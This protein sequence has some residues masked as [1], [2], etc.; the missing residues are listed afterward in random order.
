M[1]RVITIL[2]FALLGTIV[3]QGQIKIGGNV[4][5]GGNQ[6]VVNGSTKVTVK[7]GDIGAILDPAAVRPLEDPK[8]KVFGGARMANVGGNTFV[9]IDGKSEPAVANT[10][11]ILINQVFGGND[12]AGNIGTAA[13]VGEEIPAELEAVKSS[14]PSPL[15]EGETEEYYNEVDNTF[16]SYVRVSTKVTDEHYTE[17]EI[18][19]A[20]SDPDNPAFGKSTTDVKPAPDAR[21]VYIGQLFA[22]GNGDYDYEQTPSPNP[23]K[24]IHTIYDKKDKNHQNP[25]AQLET[26]EGDV[27]FQF[28]ELD[29]TYLEIKGGSI[30]YGY[31]GGNNSTINETNIIHYDN[32]SAVVNH[33]KVDANGLLD[34]NGTDLLTTER[35]KEMGINTTFSQPSS[36]A[37][38]VGRFFG[39]NNLAEMHIR[40]M[41]NLLS[42]KI[43]NLYSGGNRGSMTNPDGLLLEIMGYSTLIV[44]NLYGGC[45]MADVMPTV[46]GVYVPCSN[47]P[48][49]KFPN[50][51]SA[52]T[53]VRGGHINNVYGGNDVTG[54]VYGGNAVGIYATVYGDV[55]GGGNGNYPYTDSEGMADDDTYGDFYYETS[56]TTSTEALS[57]FRPNAEQ[58]SLRLQGTDKDNPTVIQGSVFVGGN[59]ASLD[60]KK[61][62]PLIELKMGSYVT[63]ENVFLGNNGAGMINPIYLA[64]YAET[65]FSSLNLTDASVFSDYM[66]GVAMT[67]KPRLM[68]DNIVNGDPATYVEN[69]SFVGS[70]FCGGN[71]GSM[72]IPGK[73]SFTIDHNLVIYDK[74]VGGCNK[75]NV[76]AGTYNA[77]Y[78]GGVIGSK[79]E[80]NSYTDEGGNIKD[81]LE[82]NLA[83]MTLVP[84][85][86]NNPEVKD[87]LLWNKNKWGYVAVEAGT[88]L[89][90]G[91]IYYT[92]STGAEEFTATG[93]ETATGSNYYEQGFVPVRPGPGYDNPNNRLLGANA[94]GGCYE[95][96]HV[97][98]NVV[99]NINDDVVK[100]DEVFGTGTN[101]IGRPKSNIDFEGQRDD[102][103][104]ISMSVFGAGYGEDT[105]IWGNTAVNLNNGY[106]FQIYGGG[107]KGVVGK[108]RDVLDEHGEVI[109]E[110]Y[111]FDPA[112]SSTVNL[113]GAT[114]VYS[115]DDAPEDLAEAEYLYGG[116]NEGDVCGNTYVNLGNGRIYDA[117]GGASDADILGHTEVV[118]GRQPNGSGAYKSGFPWVQDIVY[119][120]NDFGGT[121]H[122]AYEDGFDYKPR[123]R[124]YEDY[125]KQLHG[126]DEGKH[127]YLLKGSSYV[128]YLQGRVDTIFGGSYG[129]YD[130]ADIA[131]YGVGNKMPRQESAFVNLRP[132]SNDRNSIVG[133]FGAGTGYP[134]ARD[135]DKA[136][137]H[138]YVLVD[139]PHENG[140]GFKNLEVFGSGSNNGLGMREDVFVPGFDLDKA[141][142][143]VDLL[144]GEIGNAYGGSYREGNTARTVVNVP[145][146]STIRVKNI[147][148]GAYGANILPPCDVIMTNVNYRNTSENAVVTGAIYGGNNSQRRSI[149]TNVFISS[150]VWSDKSKGYLATAYGAGKGFNSWSE[151]TRVELLNGAKVYEV[152]GGGEVGH[153]LNAESVQKYM[154]LYTDNLSPEISEQDPFWSDTEGGAK[155]ST[156]D[157]KRIPNTDELK[158]KWANDWI[159][160]WTLGDYYSPIV[161]EDHEKDFKNYFERFAALRNTSLVRKA[162]IDERDYSG[163]S[164]EEKAKRQYI[165]N[166][167]VIIDEGA[168]VVNYAYGGGLGTSDVVMSGD[169]WG[170]TYIA[171]LGGKV[172]KD[173]YAAGTS[174]AVSDAFP[175]C[176]PYNA[177]TNPFGFTAS[178]T[179]YI[180][181]GSCRNVYGGGWEGNVGVHSGEISDSPATDIP[182][183]TYVVIGDLD[184]SSF[185]SGIPA[186]QRNA[187]GGGEGG[188]VY[189]TANVKLNKGY[190]GYEYKADKYVEKVEDETKETPNTL[191]VEA[192]NL[193]G[194]GYIDNSTVDKTNV[195]LNGGVVRNSVFGGGEIAAIGRGVMSGDV[196]TGIYRPGKTM[197]EMYKGHVHRNVFGGGRGYD[198]LGRVGTLNSAGYVFGQTE[199]HVHGGE[200][201]TNSGVADGDGNVFGGGDIGV[202]YSAYEKAD[203]SFGIG[204]KKGTRYDGEEHSEGYYYKYENGEYVTGDPLTE[205]CK[206]LVEPML[207]VMNAVTIGSNNYSPGE[208][209]PIED[210]NKLMDKNT[211]ASKWSCL[212]ETGIIIHNA[213]FAGGNAQ[214]GSVTTG[215]NI[216]TVFGN[217]TASIND[218]FHRDMITLGTRHT[219]GLYGDGN[220][221][222]VDGYREL[223]ITSY[224]TDYYSIAKEITIDQYHNLPEREAAYYELNYTCKAECKDRY[225]TVYHPADPE[226]PS[227]KAA[228]ITADDML[229][230]FLVYDKDT[231]KY[232]SFV[233]DGKA[234]LVWNSTEET[235]E[236]N[237]DAGYWE[238]SGVLPVYAGRLMNSIQ[239]ADFCG[240]FGSRMVMQGAQ[241]RVPE[242]ADYTNYTIN[243]VREVSLNK[244]LFDEDAPAGDYHGNYFGI[245]NIVNYLGALTSDVAFGDKRVTD[246]TAVEYRDDSE[247][248]TN[249]GT[250]VASKEYGTATYYDWKAGFVKE[251]K[252]NNGT[253]HNKVALASGVYL[254]ITSEESTGTGLYEKVWGPITGVVELDLINVSPG[255]GGGFVYA[256]NVHGVPN[257]VNNPV[258]TTLTT[259]NDEA[260]TQW[261]YTYDP[262]DDANHQMEWESSGNFIH[263]TLTIIDDCYNISNRYYG[264]GKMPAHFWYIKGS[265][266]VYDQYISAYTGQPNAYSETVDIPLTIAAASHG[267]MKLLNVMPNRYAY[268]ATPGEELGDGKKMIIN[269]KTYYKNDPISYWDWYLLSSYEQK[270]FVE[271]TY[272]NCI[273]CKIDGVEY[274]A[275]T[276]V[277]TDAEFVTYQETTHTYTDAD[278]Q[279]IKDADDKDVDDNYIFRESNNVSHDKGYILTYEVNNPSQ[280]DTWYTPK[281]ASY[282]D[283]I[284]TAEYAELTPIQQTN[285]EDG[286]TYHLNTSEGAVLGQS[287][288]QYGDLIPAAIYT[289][290]ETNVKSHIPAGEKDKQATFEMAYIVKNKITI[291]GDSGDSYYNVGTTVPASF[292]TKPAYSSSC[293]EAY[294]CTKTIEV[295]KEDIIYKDS[296]MKKSEAQS[297][298]TGV[299]SKMETEE[300]GTSE[301]TVDA[302]KKAGYSAEKTKTL[303]ALATLRDDLQTNLVQAYFCTSEPAV[304]EDKPV[305][306]YYGGN[307]YESGKNYRGLEAWSSMSAT[308]R[309]K[310]DFNYDALDLLIDPNYTT[311]ESGPKSE[312]QKYQYDSA[313]G[314][315]AGATANAAHYSLE[316]SVDYTA[317]YNLDTDLVLGTEVTV[318]R[319]ESVISTSDIKKGD[320]L[321]RKVFEDDLVNEQRYYSTIAVK[322]AGTYY[323]VNTPFQIGSTPYAVG[324]T[325]SGE[326]YT[327]LSETEKGYVTSLEFTEENTN[328]YYC[329]E[330]YTIETTHKVKSIK[331]KYTDVE[332]A[333]GETVPAG[334]VISAA[335]GDGITGYSGLTNEQRNFTIHGIS[336][337]E[338]STLYVSRESNIYDLSKEKI[339]TVIYQYDYDETDASGNV[340]PVSERHVVNI[341]LTFKSGVPI[342]EDITPPDL[343]L[344]GDLVTMREPTVTPGAYEVTGGGWEL[345]ATQRD[346]ESHVNGVE[347]NPNF[348]K[349]YWYQD[350]YYVAYYAKSYLG[351]TY[352]NAVPVS[353]AN[354]HDMADVM[355]DEYKTHH[356]Y[357]DHKNVKRYPKI[358][359]NDYSASGKN[360]LDIFKQLF[361][362]SLLTEPAESGDLAGHAL[363]DEKVKGGKDL[364]FFMRTD[365]DH[366]KPNPAYDP[367]VPGSPERII[368]PWT[369]IGTDDQCF[370]G[371]LH[372]DGHTISNLDHSLFKNL[373]GEVYNLG[374]MGTFNTAGV[375]DKGT[376][377]VESTWVKT[378]AT[379][380]LGEKPNAVFGN[381]TDTKGYQVVNSYFSNGN[382]G[383]YAN[384]EGDN[385]AILDYKETIT[386]GGDRGKATAKSDTAF[387]NGELAYDLNNFYLYKRYN[388]QVTTTG[389]DEYSYFTI[390]DDGK[391]VVQN[392]HYYADHADLCSSGYTYTPEGKT[393]PVTLMYVEDRFADGDFRYAAGEI[394]E[395]EDERYYTWKEKDPYDSS[396]EI[397]KSSFFPIWPDDY[398]FFGQKLTYGW[399]A[400][401]HQDVPTAVAR[402]E[403]R[404]SPN[405]DANR[406]YRAP[407]YFRSKQMGVAHFNPQAYLAQN[408]FDGTKEAYP[409]MT[410]IDFADHRYNEKYA[411][412]ETYYK[413]YGLGL[414]VASGSVPQMFYPP[415]LDDD[416]LTS[417]RNCDET[418]NLLVYTPAASGDGY[419]NS[420]T[421][422]VLTAYFVDPVYNTHYSYSGGYRLVSEN[423]DLINGHLVQSDLT[424]TNDHLLVDKQDFNAP[425]AYTF[426]ASHLMWYQRRPG[427]KEYVDLKNGWQGISLPFTAELVTTDT[428]GEIT[429][430]Y[431]GSETSKNGTGTKIGHEYWLRELTNGATMTEKSAGILEANF[432]YPAAAGATKTVGNTF[433]WDYYYQNTDRKD[434]NDDTYQKY[435]SS[436]RNYTAYPLLTAGTPYILGL[437]GQ[438]YYEFD[439]SGKFEAQ[440]TALPAPAKLPKQVVTFA[441]NKGAAIGV[442]DD[443]MAGKKITYGGREYTFKP[444]YM[445]E[446]LKTNINYVMNSDGNAYIKLDNSHVTWITSSEKHK[447]ENDDALTEW[448]SSNYDLYTDADGLTKATTANNTEVTYYKRVGETT[449]NDNNHVTPS[450][451]AFRPYFISALITSSG[452]TKMSPANEIV[453]T[454]DYDDLIDEPITM[455]DG[456]LEIY[457]RGHN[458]VTTS[459]L[460]NPVTLSVVSVAGITYANYTLQPGE[461]VETPVRPGVYIVNRKKLL[462]K[463]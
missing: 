17:E 291:E 270:L 134:G 57:A 172:R 230:L 174:G 110:E 419:V 128:E 164:P 198:N 207:Q 84:L 151:H 376:G 411:T 393:E 363:L 169:V 123:I 87:F 319:G 214:P 328:F 85:Q 77:A 115:N 343:I 3:A 240:V 398:I 378:S 71:V 97:N 346:A 149:F 387:Y 193:F 141:S 154:Q 131:Y 299:K 195:T 61:K 60:V 43:R 114:A 28:P 92:S 301:M 98:G 83:N 404:L 120:G 441:S 79:D 287:E 242:E 36:G 52:R 46:N 428:K 76:P 112:F 199:V 206:V 347:Y 160:A 106:V 278:N 260:V 155:W 341:H 247:A 66:E 426:D 312:G 143:V 421:H 362:L 18:R 454:G 344:P 49:Y 284:N 429:H 220:L 355:S 95:S 37:Y 413:T 41:W 448:M 331:G 237:P 272:T 251:R 51:L 228:T 434:A 175:G 326:T 109:R 171:L 116:G 256:K 12:I 159:D 281:S 300:T 99:I 139:I 39:G 69:S 147:F 385:P 162:E 136:Q 218:V 35:F 356:M 271:K 449:V 204:K 283:K 459:H 23:G 274:V 81:R 336:P 165:Y 392:N 358:Y 420:Q 418:Q 324:E 196:L 275:G 148:G 417:I 325:I 342:V 33:I 125:K 16:N 105:E 391:L 265:T 238:E 438:T 318:K 262:V 13:A 177:S 313:A 431:S 7:S 425:M 374:V 70:F 295:T 286:P 182:G 415:L 217:A 93:T 365:I 5:G 386:S 446:T 445:N 225:G 146:E 21:K 462:V 211:D 100:K 353:V 330:P 349:L 288:Y 249:G 10:N 307:Y 314:T 58:V 126:Y 399:A 65:D 31:G 124:N 186:I 285:Y 463:P 20:S 424:A 216:N 340:T 127:D 122:G 205:D 111:Y 101:F 380:P 273:T 129:F 19:L 47:L 167:N 232:N 332:Y 170:S 190:I 321:S 310:F 188:A 352:S 453:F 161:P 460:Q 82:I 2:T 259:L 410:A 75:A 156:I 118:I 223:N 194:G 403:G 396:K 397:E 59:C 45:R 163:Y 402:D 457:T 107:E 236:P 184:G 316:T 253:S 4:Y 450:Q 315:S 208:F 244:K 390:G 276:Y 423:V 56:G 263:S 27:G 372:G 422:G 409:G 150:P 26:P 401:A 34:E 436:S 451:S 252:R 388:D 74:F 212:D 337:T 257:K 94:Y 50:E 8:G 231:Q 178:A 305:H 140:E 268:Y 427:L 103:M 22:G 248:Y 38:Q 40:P 308:D 345:F 72:A 379:E 200:I 243:R 68:F 181:G 233:Y 382:K 361:D 9:H 367:D 145:A 395:S 14:M 407:A 64:K 327:S 176:G 405:D 364:V 261:D 168:E 258:N 63:V 226:N 191:L 137:D 334:A 183:K 86:W 90:K 266:Y 433:L 282:K 209:V 357:I 264:D 119:G 73:Q 311:P 440:H 78:K 350:E 132:V 11:Y 377:Y 360:G 279:P 296:K 447:F 42:G 339:I 55:Y 250:P 88:V 246:N 241:D 239:R 221:T 179:A 202:V 280:W 375:V 338:S 368:D 303:V 215:A 102:L 229:D 320:E 15:P 138:S 152:Y 439:L 25:V 234:V 1:R 369:P 384:I 130:Y 54:T 89:T 30:V 277:M 96:G 80:R 444:S 389:T 322:E 435:Y 412:Y 406:V 348:D 317:E 32:P 371:T 394:P 302:I 219:G 222:L 373:C 135:D 108:S 267:K 351:R 329:R 304:V 294:I 158:E 333:T 430:F 144:H 203:G 455:N 213:V 210:L 290:Y 173:V 62:N 458:V 24:V 354:Y 383:L 309:A 29:K 323:V 166:T 201:G 292:A 443:E 442:S 189:G 461:T 224:G 293:E 298:V 235:W 187:Y 335:S 437:P 414:T 48:G 254:E 117:F 456:T 192:G 381:P 153:V 113:N 180:K 185:T 121:I 366:T 197:V 432:H 44:D 142:A 133:V 359:I 67:Q 297:Y 306:Y 53:L 269:G 289:T 245:Y 157:G 104:A 452:S 255:I 370:E 6:G 91:G 227:S 408:S 416:G 400:E